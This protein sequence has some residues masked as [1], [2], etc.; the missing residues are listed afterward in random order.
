MLDIT[1][2]W[3]TFCILDVTSYLNLFIYLGDGNT[4]FK[5]QIFT[6]VKLCLSDVNWNTWVKIPL[7][8]L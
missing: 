7:L 3:I 1:M 8:A 2:H 6:V 5:K 4:S